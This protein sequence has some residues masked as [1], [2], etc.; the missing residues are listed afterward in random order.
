MRLPMPRKRE[1]KDEIDELFADLWQVSRLAGGRR[2]FRPPLDC[3]RTAE[4]PTFT[5]LVDLAGVDAETVR[6]TT[7]DH[8]LILTGDRR[9]EK[10]AGRSYQHME[11]EY[12]PFERIVQL[13]QDADPAGAEATYE[14][15]L[16]RIVIPIV[17]RVPR[18]G[19]VPI[20]VRRDA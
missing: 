15:G 4:P 11:I 19:A 2:A 12:G 8:A 16:L 10:C 3:Y 17:K 14:R 5:V 18:V 1:L 20:E 6:V 13:P 7:A 9:R